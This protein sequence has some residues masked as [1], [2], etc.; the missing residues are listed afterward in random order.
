MEQNKIFYVGRISS[1][2]NFE[3]VIKA[4]PLLKD[5]NVKL[6]LAGPGEE[7]YFQKLKSLIK[8]LKLEDRVIFSPAIWDIKEKIKKIDS[9][10]IF[11]IPSKSEGMPQSLIEA[12]ARKRLVIAS[13]NRAAKELIQNKEN[14][15]LFPIGNEKALAHIIDR[16]LL[17][18]KKEKLKI[19]NQA[20]ESVKQ[21]SWDKIAK[22][23]ENLI[24]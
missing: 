24:N 14:G 11:I 12:L 23:I 18:N 21:F 7:E 5:K 16:I 19:Q 2:K 8:K 6:E 20:R 1:I 10:K 13:D 4:L 17:M 3:T 22:K 15:F 9:C